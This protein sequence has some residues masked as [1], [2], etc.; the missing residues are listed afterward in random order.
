MKKNNILLV[1]GIVVALALLSVAYFC[2]QERVVLENDYAMYVSDMSGYTAQKLNVC[3]TLKVKQIPDS[4]W[5]FAKLSYEEQK[6]G[7]WQQYAECEAG[8]TTKLGP[9]VL[10]GDPGAYR[11]EGFRVRITLYQTSA[12]ESFIVLGQLGTFYFPEK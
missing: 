6:D 1:A 11:G 3:F 10:T 2:N 5:L 4:G 9:W 12:Y 7:K 8:N